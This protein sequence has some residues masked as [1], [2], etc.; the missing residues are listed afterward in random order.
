M[1]YY[2]S[3]EL[4]TGTK[5]KQTVLSLFSPNQAQESFSLFFLSLSHSTEAKNSVVSSQKLAH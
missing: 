3:G 2:W 4:S 5:K 1:L